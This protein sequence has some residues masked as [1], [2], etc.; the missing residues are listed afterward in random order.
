MN[1]GPPGEGAEALERA[2]IGGEPNI[3]LAEL[4]GAAGLTPEI[5]SLFWH[6]LGFPDSDPPGRLF[7]AGDQEAIT[8]LSRMVSDAKA[9]EEFAVGLIRA[10]GHLMSRLAMWQV[11]ALVEHMT[12][13]TG[14]PTE[15]AAQAVAFMDEH[16]DDIEPLI[17]YAWRRHLAAV[18]RWRL[19]RVTEEAVRMRLAVGFADMVGYTRLIQRMDPLALGRLVYRFE[20]VSSDVILRQGGRVIKTVGDEV[21]F[22]GDTAAQAVHIA[23]DLAEAMAADPMLPD[24]RAG[25]ATGEVVARMG[26]VYGPTVNL[27]SRLTALAN[28][29]RVLIEGA[30]AKALAGAPEIEAAPLGEAVLQ[31]FGTVAMFGVRRP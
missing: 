27:A 19:D 23:L 1:E 9:D 12:E 30:T 28:P 29:G 7:T 10:V 18:T 16:I 2:L 6:A 3:T 26:D 5:A 21:L 17:T 20:T 13:Q 4:A 25:V 31:D 8:R 11:I 15:G 14:S 22:V 24:I